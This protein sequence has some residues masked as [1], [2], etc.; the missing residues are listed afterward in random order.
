MQP[1]EVFYKIAS[2]AVLLVLVGS[3]VA[4]VALHDPATDVPLGGDFPAFY[5]AGRI[6]L[7][8]QVADLYDPEV[9]YEA[10]RGLWGPYDGYLYFAYPP[11]FA[12]LYA[13]LAAL[14][15]TAAY[16][17]HT[18]LMA[19]AV[20]LSYLALR[21]VL[22]AD[23]PHGLVLAA[24]AFT[25]F[26]LLGSVTMGQNMSLVILCW[27]VAWRLHNRGRPFLAGLALGGALFKPQYALPV[28]GLF[29][30]RR[31]WMTAIGGTVALSLWWSAGALMQGPRWVGPWLKQAFEFSTKDTAA[32]ES[33]TLSWLGLA[34]NAFG[35]GTPLAAGV[36][37]SLATATALALVRQ[38]STDRAAPLALPLA[39]AAAGSLLIAPHAIVLDAALGVL[40]AAGLWIG[41]GKRARAW[42]GLGWLLG[43]SALIREPAIHTPLI[44]IPVLGLAVSLWPRLLWGSEAHASG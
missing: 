14:P 42:I 40:T 41:E 13:P 35:T 27:S 6:V 26:P 9:Q 28:G 38:W 19:S 30:S 25:F 22:P 31:R 7:G 4:T 32:L 23:R 20:V 39:G 37:W 15:Y 16:V 36:G 11:P 10:Q 18:L 17:I 34:S 24:V 2:A 12:A 3:F 21:P 8:G 33:S 5:G 1:S 44:L 29:L 43:L